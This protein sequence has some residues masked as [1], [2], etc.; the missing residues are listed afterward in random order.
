MNRPLKTQVDIES[1]RIYA[2]ISWCMQMPDAFADAS[3]SAAG[4]W[5]RRRKPQEKEMHG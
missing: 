1:S 2:N 3:G 5:W 4:I